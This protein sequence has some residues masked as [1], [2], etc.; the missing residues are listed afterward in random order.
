MFGIAYILNYR[1]IEGKDS[2][3]YDNDI[4]LTL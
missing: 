4:V 3:N 2:T 1:R